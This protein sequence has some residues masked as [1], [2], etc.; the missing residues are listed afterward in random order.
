MQAP[1]GLWGG[2]GAGQGLQHQP[3]PPLPSWEEGPAVA[4]ERRGWRE[5][6]MGEKNHRETSDVRI[7]KSSSQVLLP[8]RRLTPGPRS[9]QPTQALRRLPSQITLIALQIAS[10][11]RCSFQLSPRLSTS[12]LFGELKWCA[13][14]YRWLGHGVRKG[15]AIAHLETKSRAVNLRNQTGELKEHAGDWQRWEW[16]H[17]WRLHGAAPQGCLDP[18]LAWV[19]GQDS[20]KAAPLGA[21]V[22]NT[23]SQG[24]QPWLAV[25]PV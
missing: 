12:I 20:A 10:R 1:V 14:S 23:P 5:T 7:T 25:L 24:A 8:R 21:S 19:A 11:I 17:W 4:S 18:G 16:L 3:T 13:Y 6:E 2:R 22:A 9:L 15:V